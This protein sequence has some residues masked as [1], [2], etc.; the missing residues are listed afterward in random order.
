MED[1]RKYVD[2]LENLEEFIYLIYVDTNDEEFNELLN[3][4]IEKIKKKLENPNYLQVIELSIIPD[5][6]KT[7]LTFGS[8]IFPLLVFKNK[9]E[10]PTIIEGIK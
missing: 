4:Y 2:N 9:G 10:A 1:I 8:S 7:L 6:L 3:S 5:N